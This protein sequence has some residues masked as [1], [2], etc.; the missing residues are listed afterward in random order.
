MVV[1]YC[2]RSVRYANKIEDFFIENDERLRNIWT[3]MS[4]MTPNTDCYY[5]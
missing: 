5:V 1:K 3:G 4:H 2:T